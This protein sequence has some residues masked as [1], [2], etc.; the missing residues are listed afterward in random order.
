MIMKEQLQL[1]GLTADLLDGMR[2]AWRTAN[3]FD[4]ALCTKPSQPDI[5]ETR[6]RQQVERLYVGVAFTLEALDLPALLGEFKRGFAR[7]KR[8]KGIDMDLDEFGNLYPPVLEY[9]SAFLSPITA[10]SAGAA[11]D[12]DNLQRLE[13][14]LIGTARL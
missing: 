13:R 14:I 3:Q 7:F 9:L 6:L 4:A 5:Y 2:R 11:A 10:A 1:D 12:G 8:S